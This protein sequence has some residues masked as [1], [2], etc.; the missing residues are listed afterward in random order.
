MESFPYAVL[1]SK[2][3]EFFSGS[4]LTTD[5]VRAKLPVN[6]PD[7]EGSVVPI[8]I[9]TTY[10]GAVQYTPA[11]TNAILLS[12]GELQTGLDNTTMFIGIG[13]LAK[14]GVR[15]GFKLGLSGVK[16]KVSEIP[17]LLKAGSQTAKQSIDEAA[18]TLKLLSK[19]NTEAAE[20]L[21]KHPGSTVQLARAVDKH[22]DVLL[23][24]IH[25]KGFAD[26]ALLSDHFGRHG[27]R[28]GIQSAL[29]YELLAKQF[30]NQPRG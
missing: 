17:S 28:M 1:Q 26:A 2:Y 12:T 16:T 25:H 11:E 27:A 8:S 18:V 20:F 6:L 21:I 29:E 4:A 3:T 23:K 10:E 5:Q 19:L 9:V 22:G 13:G 30:M 15:Q 24:Y 7:Q 14:T